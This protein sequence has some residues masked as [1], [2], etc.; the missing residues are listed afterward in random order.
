MRCILNVAREFVKKIYDPVNI[1]LPSARSSLLQGVSRLN[2]VV[3]L[4]KNILLEGQSFLYILHKWFP[5]SGNPVFPSQSKGMEIA[6]LENVRWSTG[7][8]LDEKREAVCDLERKER[9]ILPKEFP[10]P[11]RPQTERCQRIP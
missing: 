1:K 7:S 3:R 6:W 11:S 5:V 9:G 4:Q 10:S 2:K 8:C